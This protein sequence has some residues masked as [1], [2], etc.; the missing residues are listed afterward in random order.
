MMEKFILPRGVYS[1]LSYAI[2]THGL[3]IGVILDCITSK[4][5]SPICAFFRQYTTYYVGN[6]WFQTSFFT[7]EHAFSCAKTRRETQWQK[8]ID[9]H[10]V[11]L[12]NQNYHSPNLSPL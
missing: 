3:D 8:E 10:K 7:S 11:N 9:E 6:V 1:R 5:V 2:N 12:V 4:L